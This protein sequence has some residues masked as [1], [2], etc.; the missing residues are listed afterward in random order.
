MYTRRDFM[1]VTAAAAAA[2]LVGCDSSDKRTSTA[3]IPADG[4]GF[5]KSMTRATRVEM[6]SALTVVSG[7]LPSDIQGHAFTIGSIPGNGNGP[8]VVGDGFVYRLSFAPESVRLKSC[9]MRTD[10]YLLD[11]ATKDMP[12]FAFEDKTFVRVSPAFG[13]RNFANT[14]FQPIQ[15]GRL[16]VTYDAGRP[17][18]IDPTTLDVITPVGL[19]TH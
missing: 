9:V 8:Q 6:D 11:E 10:C 13:V 16:L 3:S 5:P 14:A 1:S 7:E 4:V 12:E 19:Q 15:D 18:E 17:W 2:S